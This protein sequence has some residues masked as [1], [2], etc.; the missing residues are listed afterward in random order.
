MLSQKKIDQA[1]S[2]LE[3]YAQKNDSVPERGIE[4]ADG[5]VLVLRSNRGKKC[6][7]WTLNPDERE[8][9]GWPKVLE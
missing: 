3:V 5:S 9:G 2:E 4:L 6:E 7:V 1:A 8:A